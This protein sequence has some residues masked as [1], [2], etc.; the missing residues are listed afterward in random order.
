MSSCRSPRATTLAR[1]M[2]L[3]AAFALLL[4]AYRLGLAGLAE[5]AF[6]F[7]AAWSL[8]LLAL[9]TTTV[10]DLL[11]GIRCPRCRTL[12]LR[13]LALPFAFVAYYE[14]TACRLRC[15]RS[16]PFSPW[17]DASGPED[18]EKYHRKS[19]AKRWLGYTVPEGSDLTSGTLLRSKRNRAAAP[20]R[21]ASPVRS[22]AHP[23]SR[24]E[25]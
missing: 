1:L 14:C 25:A 9:A 8:L 4:A 18:A 16:S 7:G 20:P 10:L 17:C 11:L 12:A 15:K 21:E 2:I 6:Y 23:S 19:S 5:H 24:S 13:R 3:N 22:D